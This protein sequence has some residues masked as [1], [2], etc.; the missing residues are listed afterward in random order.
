MYNCMFCIA[1]VLLCTL[2]SANKI[3]IIII[4]NGYILCWSDLKYYYSSNEFVNLK[5]FIPINSLNRRC[6][7]ATVLQFL[8]WHHHWGSLLKVKPKYSRFPRV[9]FRHDIW[10]FNNWIS[11]PYIVTTGLADQGYN[12]SVYRSSSSLSIYRPWLS[13]TM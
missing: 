7:K 2:L 13:T 10:Q 6:Y 9:S 12:I 5:N 11:A 1:I 8:S 3:I 4:I